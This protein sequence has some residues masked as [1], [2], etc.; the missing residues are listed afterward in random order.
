MR[1]FLSGMSIC[2]LL[3]GCGS[4]KLASGPSGTETG[5]AVAVR[6]VLADG[7]VAKNAR[8]EVRSADAPSQG[9]IAVV[10]RSDDSGR[11]RIRL[12]KGGWSLLAFAEGLS[13]RREI[14]VGDSDLVL[15]AD[16]LRVPARLSLHFE[17]FQTGTV[18]ELPG[19]GL[20]AEID[21]NGCARWDSVPYGTYPIREPGASSNWILR[22]LPG[23]R[24]SLFQVVDRPGCW[25]RP[26]RSAGWSGGSG[27]A[28]LVDLPAWPSA[29]DPEEWLGA[30][31]VLVP[32]VDVWIRGNGTKRSWMLPTGSGSWRSRLRAW[33]DAPKTRIF[34]GWDAGGAWSVSVDA[35]EGTEIAS[36]RDLLGG[37]ATALGYPSRPGYDSLQGWYLET[38]SDTPLLALDSSRLPVS[39]GFSLLVH[40]ATNGGRQSVFRWMETRE[41][42]GLGLSVDPDGFRLEIGGIDTS[43]VFLGTRRFHAVALSATTD[44]I[45]LAVDG[46]MRLVLPVGLGSRRGWEVPAIGVGPGLRI[47]QILTTRSAVDPVQLSNPPAALSP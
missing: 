10:A 36:L 4:D 28:A 40:A 20:R 37:A 7:S 46:R 9:A 31:G 17:S 19:S 27:A 34:D 18:V 6:L 8:V 39:G 16:T 23:A 32:Q 26:G 30:D 24:D 35:V 29:S 2:A 44:S 5:S 33:G 22:V 11:V 1:R 3:L 13:V 43:V 47:T 38:A 21:G 45:R 14:S 15:E 12:R 42:T 41:K 25:F